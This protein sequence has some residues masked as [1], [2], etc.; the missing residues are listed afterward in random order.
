MNSR[1]EVDQADE[2]DVQVAKQSIKHAGVRLLLLL[3]MK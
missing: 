3:V 2:R 1:G